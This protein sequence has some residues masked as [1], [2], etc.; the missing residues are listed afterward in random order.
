MELEEF[1]RLFG[2]GA[3]CHS[4][5][6]REGHYA[7]AQGA[8]TVALRIVGAVRAEPDN[9]TLP[10]EAIYR[11]VGN[12]AHHELL[13]E[14]AKA[15]DV[16]LFELGVRFPAGRP[17]TRRPL[18]R[19]KLIDELRGHPDMTD[20]HIE[21]RALDLGAWTWDQAQDRTSRRRRLARLREDA[22]S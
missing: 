15:D 22:A 5:G 17:P 13:G 4:S 14:Q 21:Q 7:A 10:E 3:E 1:K 8:R 2:L 11:Y 16:I 18:G 19:Q 20:E 12:V 9:A 6:D